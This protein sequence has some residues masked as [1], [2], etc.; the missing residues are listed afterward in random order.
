MIL[1]TAF[2][3]AMAA[4]WLTRPKIKEKDKGGG[5]GGGEGNPKKAQKPASKKRWVP[6]LAMLLVLLTFVLIGGGMITSGIAFMHHMKGR[7]N[8]AGL[9][10]PASISYVQRSSD[11]RTTTASGYLYRADEEAMEFVVNYVYGDGIHFAKHYTTRFVW[12]KKDN[13]RGEYNQP[14]P[15]ETGLWYLEKVPK[16]QPY[17]PDEWTGQMFPSGGAATDAMIITIRLQ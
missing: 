9:Q 1:A 2:V 5:E 4:F 12:H 7:K 14:N 17:A 13:E 10:E 8:P 6:S 15:A 3:I 11:G 16:K